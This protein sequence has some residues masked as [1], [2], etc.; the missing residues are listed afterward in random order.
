LFLSEVLTGHEPITAGA[1]MVP[2]R[3]GSDFSA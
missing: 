2:I 3:S 1:R